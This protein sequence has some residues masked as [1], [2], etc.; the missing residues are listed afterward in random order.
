MSTVCCTYG[1]LITKKVYRQNHARLGVNNTLHRCAFPYLMT[2]ALFLL[3]I[4]TNGFAVAL[5]WWQLP[6]DTPGVLC[7]R[8][9]GVELPLGLKQASMYHKKLFCG[10]VVRLW[11]TWIHWPARSP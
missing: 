11:F 2:K 8:C 5:S 9:S 7:S 4:H 10:F 1:M 6:V 3:T